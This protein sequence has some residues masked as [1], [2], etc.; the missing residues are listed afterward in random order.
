MRIDCRQLRVS[1]DN[2]SIDAGVIQKWHQCGGRVHPAERG[3]LIH[4]RVRVY[5]HTLAL[6]RSE[7]RRVCHSV[8]DSY[9]RAIRNTMDS[10]WGGAA[11]CRPIGRPLS[12]KPHGT[13]IAGSPVRLNGSAR[14]MK[15]GLI[16]FTLPPTST[17]VWPMRGGVIAS[18]GVTSASTS[19]SSSPTCRCNTLRALCACT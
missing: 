13:E 19:L 17:D 9:A 6:S 2:R 3:H 14:R 8:A 5:N 7:G 11:T 1:H 15:T 16:S 12:P 4:M 18:A 10:A